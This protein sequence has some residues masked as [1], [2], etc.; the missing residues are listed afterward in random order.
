MPASPQRATYQTL[1]QTAYALPA[2]DA[3]WT[4]WSM[5]E[6]DSYSE[7]QGQVLG[8]A[9]FSQ[10][11]GVRT[12][13]GSRLL[14]SVGEVPNLDRGNQTIAGHFVRVLRE[15]ATGSVYLGNQRW[16]PVWH[17]IME[18]P[19]VEPDADPTGNTGGRAGWAATGIAAFMAHIQ[20]GN[21]YVRKPDGTAAL[22]AFLPQFNAQ[23]GGDRSASTF[24]TP[25]G[26][27]VYIA[28]HTASGNK[29]T[30]KQ[31]LDYVAAAYVTSIN[32]VISDPLGA[33][34][35]EPET[36]NLDGA[37]V[38]QA[39]NLI[40][41]PAR[42]LT[43]SLTVSGNTV[44]L[45]VTTGTSTGITIGSFTV[46]AASA[47][48]VVDL[49]DYAGMEGFL[50]EEDWSQVVDRI[51]VRGARP[52][53]AMTL[54]FDGSGSA[55]LFG[56]N[57]GWTGAAQT[58]WTSNP[59]SSLTDHV[60]RRFEINAAWNGQQYNN[61]S[62]G[63]RNVLTLNGSY[64]P[65][66]YDG[67]RTYDGTQTFPPANLIKAER[68]LP[69]SPG[70]STLTV[71]PRQNPV[72]V[73]G[74]GSVW[75]DLTVGGLTAQ[76]GIQIDDGP[77]SVIID[78]GNKGQDI[79]ALL[80]TKTMLV[81]V[82]VREVDPLLVAWNTPPGTQANGQRR[83]KVINVPQCEQW[84]VLAGTVTGV[85]AAPTGTLVTSA[86]VTI[87]DDTP[88]MRQIL[89]LAV[90]RFGQ[91]AF[92]ARWTE[93]GYFDISALTKPGRLLTQIIRGDKNLA[94]EGII[95]RRTIRRERTVSD[96]NPDVV[97]QYWSTSYEVEQLNPDLEAV[98]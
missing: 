48:T 2:S 12:V 86:G 83:V 55:P 37:S 94:V 72:V 42:G 18:G 40:I 68:A 15:D 29:W 1:V 51:E 33:L 54:M 95:T 66:G 16:S 88:T 77:L 44:T 5:L 11:F 57:Y 23:P 89:A 98:L 81:T 8:E 21:G 27:S 35:W 3:G 79:A 59:D 46:P 78:D 69:C 67:L 82:G 73:V 63:L 85:S 53:I 91:P 22:V 28:N 13:P 80:A 52:W 19:V 70:F 4:T 7:G 36:L 26:K 50:Y 20:M 71:G 74:S 90:V 92:A 84:G 60:W 47:V 75:Q 58:V 38:L 9:R 97:V 30:A 87:R 39:V 93:R 17:G 49:R 76:W 96:L 6:L 34:T 25:T 45:T 24:T 65:D 31:I 10:D 14:W 64:G 56:A 41:N 62:M 61:S 43:W 32:L